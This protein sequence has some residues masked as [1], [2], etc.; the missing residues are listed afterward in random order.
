[1]LRMKKRV[2]STAYCLLAIA[3]FGILLVAASKTAAQEQPV[4]IV[5]PAYPLLLLHL[6][7]SGSVT[8]EM[9]IDK[10]GAVTAA[11]MKD[12]SKLFYQPARRAAMQWKFPKTRTDARRTFAVT[13]KFTLLPSEAAPE[14]ATITFSPPNLV[15]IKARRVEI[16][17]SPSY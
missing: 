12:G 2:S 9:Q 8:I 15:E 1:M 14:D 11:T 6:P 3:A 13:F 10:T 16:D 17:P 5:V 4:K 7:A